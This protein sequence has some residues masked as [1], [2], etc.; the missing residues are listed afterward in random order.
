[1]SDRALLLVM[2]DVDPVHEDELERW[3]TEEH[4]P[5]RVS[6]PGFLSARRYVA[7]EGAPKYLALYDLEN[8]SV[9][10]SPAYLKI[11]DP[12]SPWTTAVRKHFRTIIR[13]VYVDITQ[14]HAGQ[15]ADPDRT[16]NGL[17]LVMADSGPGQ[18]DDFNR[19]YDEEHM[20]ERMAVPGFLRARR[21]KAV[22]GSPK[23]LALYDLEA[24]EVLQSAAYKYY[25][26][27][28]GETAWTRRVR[29]A[30]QN[31]QRNVYEAK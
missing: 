7:R 21:F 24:P 15:S 16:G 23:Y 17:L 9:L 18:E 31:F 8:V 5:E 22:E 29:G 4:F 14:P 25:L 3:Y 26:T 27:G 11:Y 1:M 30:M 13:N 19:W 12:P 20:A 6:C 28:A 10:S 2:I